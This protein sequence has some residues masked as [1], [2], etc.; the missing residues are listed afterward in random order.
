M[1]SHLTHEIKL[2]KK[3]EEI[4]KKRTTLLQEMESLH[5][6]H[7]NKKQQQA[8][9]SEAAFKRNAQL[10]DDLQEIEKRLKTRSLPH[11]DIVSLETRYWA[12]VEEKIPEW[13]PFLLGRGPSP[14]REGE[15]S[16]RR[17]RKKKGSSQDSHHTHT[18]TS[19]PPRSSPKT[20]I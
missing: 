14:V 11:P 10:L 6:Q 17:T 9:D 19:L 12:S 8:M 3:Y 4:L 7:K 13:E 18:V 2:S 1:E 16:Q 5:E 15:K 20:V